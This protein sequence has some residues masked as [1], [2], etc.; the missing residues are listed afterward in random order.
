MPGFETS[1]LDPGSRWHLQC[2]SL[3]ADQSPVWTP[4]AVGAAFLFFCFSHLVSRLPDKQH[5]DGQVKVLSLLLQQVGVCSGLERCVFS[6]TLRWSLRIS[7]RLPCS[8]CWSHCRRSCW[9]GK[10]LTSGCR[11]HAAQKES[12]NGLRAARSPWANYVQ[13]VFSLSHWTVQSL[14]QLSTVWSCCSGELTPLD[15]AVPILW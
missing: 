6:K 13:C 7:F 4:A 5:V 10:G 15:A 9:Q 8:S 2:W 3:Q 14:P 1:H 12:V 11:L